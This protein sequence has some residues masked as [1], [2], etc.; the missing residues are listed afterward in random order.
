MHVFNSRERAEVTKRASDALIKAL[1]MNAHKDILLVAAGGSVQE[2]LSHCKDRIPTLYRSFTVTTLDERLHPQTNQ[3]NMPFLKELFS[4]AHYIDPMRDNEYSYPEIQGQQWNAALKTWFFEHSE[5]YVCA[6]MGMG[7][8]GHIAGIFK[9]TNALS[10]NTRFV[11]TRA[12][13]VGYTVS[14]DSKPQAT[15]KRLTVTGHF[16][17]YFVHHALLYVVGSEKKEALHTFARC[18]HDQVPAHTFPGALLTHLRSLEL[19]TDQLV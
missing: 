17:T 8:D 1:E 11:D 6:I 4:K 7:S 10:F 3:Q 13:A 5:Q 15:P 9:D 18:D 14:P 19:Y 2:L 16:L 12:L